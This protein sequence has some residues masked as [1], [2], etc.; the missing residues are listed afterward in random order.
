MRDV[1]MVDGQG[2]A[3]MAAEFLK[4]ADVPPAIKGFADT[5]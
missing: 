1:A 2:G 4:L 5:A 3:L